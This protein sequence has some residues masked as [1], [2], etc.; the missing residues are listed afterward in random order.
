[1]TTT[2]ADSVQTAVA[3][4]AC[5][6]TA[7]TRKLFQKSG[8]W[9]EECAACQHRFAQPSDAL[10]HVAEVYGDDYFHGGGAGYSNYLSESRLL[11][12]HGRRYGKLLKRFSSPGR[13]L[14]VGAAAGFILKG[15]RAE[16]WDGVGVE[17]NAAMARHAREQLGIK[18]TA[19]PFE[20]FESAEPFDV[21]SVIQVMAHFI[22][23]RV[24]VEHLF[25]LLKPGGIVVV[26]TWNVRSWSARMFGAGWHEYSPP[27]V[28]QWWSPQT[29][30]ELFSKCGFAE[31][32]TGR[33]QKWI[34]MGHAKSLIRHKAAEGSWVA[35]MISAGLAIVPDRLQVPYPSEDLFWAV[36]RKTSSGGR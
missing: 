33:P 20:Q 30:G 4:P 23:P 8:I 16:G 13:L 17:P 29:L 15:L 3:C 22:E 9:I 28:L 35:K 2:V 11:E 14:D 25:D 10:Q 27:S 24:A 26:E 5:D 1:M 18:V 21:I 12:A 36:Y 31:V 32:A 19:A 7:P 34:E 6:R